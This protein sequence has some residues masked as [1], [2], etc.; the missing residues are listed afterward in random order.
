MIHYHY[1][2]ISFNQ[3]DR[4][5]LQK[6]GKLQYLWY[7]P[8]KLC[9]FPNCIFIRELNLPHH[10]PHP[11]AELFW[12]TAGA[13]SP[14]TSD[15]TCQPGWPSHPY[16]VCNVLLREYVPLQNS[17]S[18]I[19][20][21]ALHSSVQYGVLGPGLAGPYK[22][23]LQTNITTHCPVA[24]HSVCS[25]TPQLKT[26]DIICFNE[27]LKLAIL[28]RHKT[29]ICSSCTHQVASRWTS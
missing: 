4:T 23:T 16:W 10:L 12:G 29:D 2:I 26:C 24:K 21:P 17:L 19:A 3:W 28:M 20:E 1:F 27:C 18:L 6:L 8:R 5:T 22:D 15:Q 13:P 14:L 9:S 7:F 11:G 25:M